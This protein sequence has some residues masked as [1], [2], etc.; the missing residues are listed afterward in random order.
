MKPKKLTIKQFK[1]FS[2]SIR[3]VLHPEDL[4]ALATLLNKEFKLGRL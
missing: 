3:N 1:S 2:E 4:E